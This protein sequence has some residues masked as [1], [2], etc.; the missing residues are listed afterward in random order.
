MTV[1]RRRRTSNLNA[2]LWLAV[3][4][5]IAL[6][7][8]Q[9]GR[10]EG[11]APS[12][13]GQRLSPMSALMAEARRDN[14]APAAVPATPAIGQAVGPPTSAIGSLQSAT[15]A[16]ATP[17]NVQ[18][19]GPSGLTRVA[20]DGGPTGH[21]AMSNAADSTAASAY[22][23]VVITAAPGEHSEWVS[24][25]PSNPATELSS[26]FD[27]LQLSPDVAA[28]GENGTTSALSGG[29]GWLSTLSGGTVRLMLM[30]GVFSLAPA[31]L[32]MTTSYVRIVVVLSLLK[33][34]IGNQQALPAQA[35]TALALFITGLVM[36]PVWQS[37]YRDA[38][39]PYRQSAGEMPIQ[40]A[41]QAGVAPVRQF[42]SRQIDQMDNSEDVWLFFRYLPEE[43][44]SEPPQTYADVP[45]QVLLPAFLLSELKTAFL[46]GFQIYLPFLVLDFV[47][48]T[49]TSSMG[50]AMLSPATVSFPFKLMLFV[51]VDGW[52]LVAGTL[53]ESFSLF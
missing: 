35:T 46:I 49:M 23:E 43:Q 25:L 4:A 41:W 9:A 21:G 24:V 45:L 14:A 27:A 10:V 22:S 28:A 48:A 44:R 40:D 7:A 3:A 18:R 51:L 1:W 30:L 17:A 12:G 32:L 8:A 34:A 2:R 50:L 13:Y 37:V 52:R 47:I 42:M 26:S 53:L 20:R 19:A 11:Q 5:T 33:Q 6:C 38:V 36:M 29:D 39:Q 31:A 15:S 16:S